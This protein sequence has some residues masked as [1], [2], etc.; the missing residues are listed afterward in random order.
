MQLYFSPFACSLASHITAR[1]AGLDISLI[2]VA[3]A[4]KR[5]ADGEDFLAIAPKGQV[6]ALRLDEGT[7]LT[8][9]PAVLQY[10]ADAAPTRRPRQK[11]KSA[12]VLIW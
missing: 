10:L 7:V 4:T 5:T 1:E 6:P 11:Y 9:G 3:L 12:C 2:S 8:E